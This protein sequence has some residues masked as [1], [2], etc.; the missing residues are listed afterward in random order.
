MK[1][2]LLILVGVGAYILSLKVVPMIYQIP[3]DVPG[4]AIS[5]SACALGLAFAAI[6]L[7]W[8]KVS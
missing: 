1:I 2:L 6:V 7:A 4:I 5:Q 3:F 8:G